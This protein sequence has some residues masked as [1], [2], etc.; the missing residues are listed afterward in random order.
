[1]RD[2]TRSWKFGVGLLSAVV[3]S[4]IATRAAEKEPKAEWQVKR[5]GFFENRK[6]KSQLNLIF[7][8]PRAAFD[9]SD[10]EDAALIL[11]SFLQS[12]GYLEPLVT[13]SLTDPDG[14]DQ[15][16]EWDK[17][18]DV[19]LSRETAVTQARFDI[20]RGP[21]FFYESLEI[22]GATG[23]TTEEAATFFYSPQLLFQS[24]ESRV[25]TP[26]LLA[27]GAGNLQAHL[28]KFLI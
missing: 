10:I 27:S 17:N 6:L 25:Y 5:L 14:Q 8:E 18:L 11:V 22:D 4:A 2:S 7:Q 9:A 19:F 3:L 23:L 28:N 20:E 12:Q 16:V 1:M 13:A 26:A 24:K 21:R 15:V